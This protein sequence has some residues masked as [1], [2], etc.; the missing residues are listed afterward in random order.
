MQLQ[1]IKVY[2]DLLELMLKQDIGLLHLALCRR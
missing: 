1:H 2:Q